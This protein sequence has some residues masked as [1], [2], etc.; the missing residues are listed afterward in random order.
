MA[1][2]LGAHDGYEQPFQ[3]LDANYSFY[4]TDN[5]TFKLKVQNL[6]DEIIESESAGVVAFAQDPGISVALKVKYDF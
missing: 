3:S 5:W 4:P 6:L 2:G 1:G